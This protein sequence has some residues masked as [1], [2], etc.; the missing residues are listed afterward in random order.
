VTIQVFFLFVDSPVAKQ[1]S[2]I[3]A[4]LLDDTKI[5]E[6]DKSDWIEEARQIIVAEQGSCRFP[7]AAGDNEPLLSIRHS[8]DLPQVKCVQ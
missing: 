6:W 1:R 7:F 4:S 2:R 3:E 5:Q 8:R